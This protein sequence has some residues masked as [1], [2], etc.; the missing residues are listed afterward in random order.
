MT[1]AWGQFAP[2]MQRQKQRERAF[3]EVDLAVR[4]LSVTGYMH[5]MLKH[6]KK[7]T[8]KK[9]MPYQKQRRPFT[10]RV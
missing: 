4:L 5:I 8:V 1:S 7:T 6:M 3:R 10:C 2:L 9:N